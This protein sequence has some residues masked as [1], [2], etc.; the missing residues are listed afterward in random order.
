MVQY[1]LMK[2]HLESEKSITQYNASLSCNVFIK[3]NCLHHP[4]TETSDWS[5]VEKTNLQN[6]LLAGF[7]FSCPRE[8][9]PSQFN[10]VL[11]D[12]LV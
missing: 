11:R 6:V 12:D 10:C 2:R 7:V 9:G 4:C 1:L 8:R 3:T 5:L